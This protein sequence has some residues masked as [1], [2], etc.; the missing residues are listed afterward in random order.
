MYSEANHQIQAEAMVLAQCR[1]VAEP[2]AARYV[3][4]VTFRAPGE[5]KRSLADRRSIIIRH[6]LENQ[7]STP[8]LQISTTGHVVTRSGFRKCSEYRPKQQSD[9]TDTG[10]ETGIGGDAN[11]GS[12]LGDA[13]SPTI[14]KHNSPLKSGMSTSRKAI[15]S[16]MSISD[17]SQSRPPTDGI[18]STPRMKSRATSNSW[19]RRGSLIS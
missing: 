3:S 11:P 5:T 1:L 4:R 15:S 6:R 18:H 12:V 13:C 8:Y 16:L 9:D 19:H 14:K 2:P 7:S 17:S 10:S